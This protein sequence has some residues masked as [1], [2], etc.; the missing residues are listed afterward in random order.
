MAK[1]YKELAT[2]TICK[3]RFTVIKEKGVYVSG[4]YC[5]PCREKYYPKKEEAPKEA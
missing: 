2:C 1:L 4:R 3:G 5:N